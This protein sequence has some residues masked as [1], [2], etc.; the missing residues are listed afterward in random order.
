MIAHDS[1]PLDDTGIA[2]VLYILILLPLEN[3]DRS[4]ILLRVLSKR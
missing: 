3:S 1:L 2:S 4:N